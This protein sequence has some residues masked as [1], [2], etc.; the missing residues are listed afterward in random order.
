[1]VALENLIDEEVYDVLPSLD[2]V[3]NDIKETITAAVRVLKKGV[4]VLLISLMLGSMPM[5]AQASLSMT[6]NQYEIMVDNK[7]NNPIIVGAEEACPN[8]FRIHKRIVELRGLEENWDGY[9][10][11]KLSD[12]ALSLTGSFA[13]ML[14]EEVL[15]HC[16]VFPAAN[17]DVYLQGRFAKGS[18]IATFSGGN[19]TYVLKGETI[20]KYSA[21]RVPLYT[22]TV[23]KLNEVIV[24]NLLV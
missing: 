15:G 14:S 6:K 22:E 5:N 3:L 18:L 20:E 1:M 11:L 10:A 13:D 17:S 16:S 7:S 12:N 2:D 21:T 23:Q 24:G 19:L 9:G 8:H 4:S